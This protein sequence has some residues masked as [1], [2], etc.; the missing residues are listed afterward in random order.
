MSN[1]KCNCWCVITAIILSV[2]VGVVTAF[3]QVTGTITVTTAFLWVVFGIA[4]GLLAI[5]L[6]AFSFMRGEAH[7][8][9]CSVITALIIG[10]LG[11]ILFSLVLLGIGIVAT[12]VLTAIFTGL[13]LFFFWLAITATACAVRIIAGC[14]E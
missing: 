6:L 10:I 13:I 14:N 12:S 9:I 1:C 4:V 3:L 7:R 8:C 2:I 5:A 11:T